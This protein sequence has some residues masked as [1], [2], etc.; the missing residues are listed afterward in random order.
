MGRKAALVKTR[1]A[2]VK[3]RPMIQLSQKKGTQA[4]TLSLYCPR[5]RCGNKTK[6]GANDRQK[7][8]ISQSR[9]LHAFAFPL[10]KSLGRA[11][12]CRFSRKAWQK[13]LYKERSRLSPYRKF[14]TSLFKGLCILKAKPLIANAAANSLMILQAHEEVVFYAVGLKEE[15]PSPEVSPVFCIQY[16]SFF[17]KSNAKTFV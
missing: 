8:P 12:L 7:C 11:F 17:V 16:L 9:V 6:I 5:P 14:G 1:W 10:I 15:K 2:C 3:T 13:L 4:R